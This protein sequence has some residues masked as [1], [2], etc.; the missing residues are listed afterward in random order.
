MIRKTIL[1]FFLFLCLLNAQD[2]IEITVKGISDNTNNGAQQ[3]RQEAIMDAKRQ[4]CEKSGVKLKSV[5]NV[6]NFQTTFDYI[7]SKAEA[8]L[9]PGFQVIDVGYTQD[10]TYQVVLSGKVKVIKDDQDDE[11]ISAKELRYAKTLHDKGDYYESSQLLEKYINSEEKDVSEA[12]KEEAYYLYIKW[13]YS[14]DV[15]RDAEKFAAFYPNS[16]KVE[17]LTQ[18]AAFAK[19]KQIEYKKSFSVDDDDWQDGEFTIDEEVYQ[20][21]KEIV[22]ETIAIKDFRYTSYDVIVEFSIYQKDDTDA[23]DPA[24][25]LF[26]LSY[27]DGDE[28]K[29][30]EERAKTLSRNNA[31]TFHHSSSGKRFNH[32]TFKGYTIA[33]DIPVDGDKYTL[34]LQFDVYPKSF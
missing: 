27:K 19:N 24:A 16:D 12:L 10:G 6:E 32:F 26:K 29:V 33:G 34:S 30:I 21:K 18:F 11:H 9:L 14:F 22:S 31:M 25:Y 2:V 20:K 15:T 13:G 28:V 23:K 8:V 5:T 4:A 1:I 17:S 3:D 7:E